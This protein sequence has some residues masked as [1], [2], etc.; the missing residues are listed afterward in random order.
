[1]S[2]LSVMGRW[3]RQ[4]IVW[5][6]PD[7]AA[8]PALPLLHT[9]IKPELEW[10][11]KPDQGPPPEREVKSEAQA[12]DFSLHHLR[13]DLADEAWRILERF[14][15]LNVRKADYAREDLLVLQDLW[16]CDFLLLDY[17]LGKRMKGGDKWSVVDGVPAQETIEA[18]WPFDYAFAISR[19]Q[20]IELWRIKSVEPKEVR[21][22]VQIVRP[23][24]IHLIVGAF[25]DNG[26]WSCG[27]NYFGLFDE[28]WQT[29]TPKGDYRFENFDSY[30]THRYSEEINFML[31]SILAARY[32]WHVAFG[33]IAGGPRILF[34]TN[35]GGALKLFKNRELELGQTRRSAL[36]HWCKNIGATAM[37]RACN[38]SVAICVAILNSSGASW[39]VSCLSAPTIWKKTN[40]S[41]N[42]QAN[43][44]HSANIIAFA[45]GLSVDTMGTKINGQRRKRLAAT[46]PAQ[47]SALALP[48]RATR[49]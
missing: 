41:S 15:V 40:F 11:P 17:H 25:G 46:V 19:D 3:L 49:P 44:E 34:P 9:R 8:E 39:I 33:T 18:I 10:E 22:I 24:M 45:F 26:M 37:K 30:W 5:F 23:R 29:L 47:Q 35:P 12:R 13:R 6:R 4:A 32:E 21:G 1:V 2:F 42:R 38:M 7:A 14:E 20:Q 27:D 31:P 28:T 16:G 48:N 36:K 43:G